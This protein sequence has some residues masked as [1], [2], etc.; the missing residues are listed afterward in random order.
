MFFEERSSSER[1]SRNSRLT[2]ITSGCKADLPLL[3]AYRSLDCTSID[4][5]F[6]MSWT[7]AD[8]A[9]VFHA[10]RIDSNAL[11]RQSAVDVQGRPSGALILT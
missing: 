1:F 8:M 11:K 6:P 9:A 2:I 3:P 4:L 7:Y 10:R 5:A